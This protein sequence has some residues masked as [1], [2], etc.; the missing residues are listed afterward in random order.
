MAGAT[1][2][3]AGTTRAAEEKG[4]QQ[5]EVG[6]AEDLMREHGVLRR[7]MLVYD[8]AIRRLGAAPKPP[9]DLPTPEV[10]AAVSG[11]SIVRRV[12]EDYHEKLEER[13][14]FP[15]FEK[16]KRHV[17]LVATLR[18]QHAAGRKLTDEVVRLAKGTLERD[19]DRRA[20]AEVLRSFNRMYRPHAAW[21]DTV[22]FPA[23]HEMLGEKA[24]R[25]L[26][27]QFEDEERRKL[28]ASGFEGAVADV[29]QIEQR[30]GIHDLRAFTPA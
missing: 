29:G 21:E 28:G 6:P 8:E 1:I 25:D 14:L 18:Q 7:V 11:A 19:S 2:L 13:F 20:L 4:T 24:Y 26:G 15:P 23:F 27:E 5:P 10:A 3:A 12:I 9:R 16:A 17:D 30:L 22:L